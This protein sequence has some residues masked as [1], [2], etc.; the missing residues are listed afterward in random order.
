[1][2]SAAPGQG[3]TVSRRTVLA[4]VPA[5][6]ALYAAPGWA[7]RAA[8]PARVGWVSYVSQP[9]VTVE[10]LRLG[11]GELGH[12]EGK[13]YVLIPRFANGDFTRIPT[14]V[15]ELMV[16]RIDVL[17]SRGP[18]VN[19]LIPVRS[20]VPIVFSYSGD[21]VAAGFAD[22][23]S[24]PGRNRHVRVE[25]VHR[26]GG[27][28]SYAPGVFES[29]KGMAKFVDKILKGAR[30]EPGADRAGEPDPPDHQPGRRA[31]HRFD[32]SAVDSGPGRPRHRIESTTGE[33]GEDPR[34]DA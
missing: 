27:L 21:P 13:S 10:R 18:T 24:R 31:T 14:L 26:R 15:D 20:H 12:V 25:R 11:L 23:L 30:R 33:P 34:R 6:V 22:S 29:F 19:Y 32:R 17:V 4:L 8:G 2:R 7:Q 3:N 28:I 1:M 5:L 9:D 16:E